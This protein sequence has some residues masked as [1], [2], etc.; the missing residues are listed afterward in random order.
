MIIQ[1]ILVPLLAVNDTTLTVVEIPLAAG[2]PVRKGDLVMVF[3][4]SKTTYD[5]E[6]PADG[7]IQYL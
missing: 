5:V 7:Y 3:E 4:T 6:A 1:E 2:S